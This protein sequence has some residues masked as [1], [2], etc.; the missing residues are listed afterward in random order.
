MTF[1]HQSGA[2]DRYIEE[3]TKQKMRKSKSNEK[4]WKIWFTW[5]FVRHW[6]SRLLSNRYKNTSFKTGYCLPMQIACFVLF[7]FPSLCLLYNVCDQLKLDKTEKKKEK[8]KQMKWHHRKMLTT[9]ILHL[10]NFQNGIKLE[11]YG[12]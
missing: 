10:E 12:S 4:C 11:M 9:W 8:E 5:F 6:F 3:K 7:T 2:C 1:A